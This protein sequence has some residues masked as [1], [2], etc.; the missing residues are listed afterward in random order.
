MSHEAERL[1]R[2]DPA[3]EAPN[4]EFSTYAR[5][6]GMG[7]RAKPGDD[8]VAQGVKIGYSVLD[9]QMRE[10][11]RL[12]ERLR[13][14]MRLGAAAP[15]E[16][17]ALIERALNIYRDMGSLA[18]AAAEALAG[19]SSLRGATPEP[20]PTPAPASP[21]AIEVKSARRANVKLDLRGVA[22]AP[23]VG[24]LQPALGGGKPIENVRFEPGE[25]KLSLEIADDQPAG[26][27][28]AVVVDADSGEAL[29]TLTVR[30]TA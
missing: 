24:P 23:R 16:F 26:V 5:S 9:E 2:Q 15:P 21:Y 13:G 28:N 4:R 12:A 20:A 14:G 30:I 11:R 29:G 1:H 6:F 10:G 19:A 25:P 22:R 7:G 18:F 3:R 17:G 27:Y 8:P